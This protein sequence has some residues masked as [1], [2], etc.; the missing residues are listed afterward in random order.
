MGKNQGKSPA[1]TSLRRRRKSRDYVDYDYVAQ[2]S[3]DE[4]AFL[5][6]FTDEY[7][8][9]NGY[10][11][12]RPL[13]DRKEMARRNY[14]ARSDIFNVWERANES[15]NLPLVRTTE[16]DLVDAIDAGKSPCSIERRVST[17]PLT[18]LT[19]RFPPPPPKRND[20]SLGRASLKNRPAIGRGL[21]TQTGQPTHA[22]TCNEIGANMAK[23]KTAPA[24]AAP[25][26]LMGDAATPLRNI[27]QLLVHGLFVGGNAVH[28]GNSIE[29]LDGM[30]AAHEKSVADAT[31]I[32]GAEAKRARKGA[33]LKAAAAPAEAKT[34]GEA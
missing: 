30:I 14:A 27:K 8:N 20:H 1:L 9:G 31:A 28:V 23:K 32:A 33:K 24:Q 26:P 3:D 15:A 5:N 2:L 19:T 7:Y 12:E 6:Q 29:F 22:H 16:D 17:A 10:A 34:D 18:C 11:F 13:L 4:R 21:L 25:T